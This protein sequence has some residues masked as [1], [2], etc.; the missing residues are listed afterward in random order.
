MDI[1]ALL[2]FLALD[3]SL[4][5]YV[6]YARVDA[7]P[8]FL[9]LIVLEFILVLMLVMTNRLFSRAGLLFDIGYVLACVYVLAPLVLMFTQRFAIGGGR[10]ETLFA[11]I[12][13][14]SGMAA[15]VL[16]LFSFL[17]AGAQAVLTLF[18]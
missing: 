5:G 4:V 13:F 1:T 3:F 11:N 6:I 8:E 7:L 18:A 9:A 17:I 15:A 14:F 16:V 10:V 2:L 12:G